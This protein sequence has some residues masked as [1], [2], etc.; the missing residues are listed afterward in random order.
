MNYSHKKMG[1]NQVTFLLSILVISLMIVT[2]LASDSVYGQIMQDVS[3][4]GCVTIP[5]DEIQLYKELFPIIIWTDDSTYDH[6][7]ILTVNG[8]LKPVNTFNPVTI[9]ITNPIGNLIGIEQ[10]TPSVNGD[11]EIKFNTGGKLWNH[12]GSYIIRAQSGDQSRSFK[13]SIELTSLD[14]GSISECTENEIVTPA[15]NGGLYCIP[16][17]A[18]GEITGIEGFLSTESSTLVLNIRGTDVEFVFID[19]PRYILNAKTPN[20]DDS[21]FAVLVN[22]EPGNFEE[23]ASKL[24]NHR[25]LAITY[26]PDRDGTIEI[27]GTSA[28]PEF[29]SITVLVLI[30]VITA[31]VVIT[32]RSQVVGG[33]IQST[34]K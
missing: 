13:T 19:I 25:R 11:F 33:L 26:P 29:G 30:V 23:Q 15:D 14:L 20:D 2:A 32:T 4:P 10:A 34:N 21:A 18:T 5:S 24:D 22:G 27:I 31:V 16:F 12:D 8:Y 9:T 7:S 6:K 1:W 28:I 3:C 17:H